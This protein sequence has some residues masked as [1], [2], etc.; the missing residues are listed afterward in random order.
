[1]LLLQL[2]LEILTQIFNLVSDHENVKGTHYNIIKLYIACRGVKYFD[3]HLD[4]LM[5]TIEISDKC[6]R[7]NDTMTN[8]DMYITA[9]RFIFSAFEGETTYTKYYYNMA[10]NPLIARRVRELELCN[11][12]SNNFAVLSNFQN[13]L[14]LQI[15]SYTSTLILAQLPNLENLDAKY[16]YCHSKV[17][18]PKMHTLKV[19]LSN[20]EYPSANSP[21]LSYD[22]V[23]PN[24][25]CL[26]IGGLNSYSIQPD[27]KIGNLGYLKKLSINSCGVTL[28]KLDQL[29]ELELHGR[30]VVIF[31]KQI[32]YSNFRRA[33][34][35][36]I[37][38]DC[39]PN[40][41]N[42]ITFN[43]Y[44]VLCSMSRQLHLNLIAQLERQ[45]ID[46]IMLR[47]SMIHGLDLKPFGKL[48]I[49]S[50]EFRTGVSVY[51]AGRTLDSVKNLSLDVGPMGQLHLNG[52]A[53]LINLT[54]SD[55]LTLHNINDSLPNFFVEL[56]V[57]IPIVNIH[58]SLNTEDIKK[59]ICAHR[60]LVKDNC[61]I[62]DCP[63]K[64][65]ENNVLD[66]AF[67]KIF[68]SDRTKKKIC[69]QLYIYSRTDTKCDPELLAYAAKAK[70]IYNQLRE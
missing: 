56:I 21:I 43:A 63:D 61:K 52:I 65:T 64:T 57:G 60:S 14:R 54:N 11:A 15:D 28:G 42:F 35:I 40:L 51:A 67:Q 2:A 59:F 5:R 69:K 44:D 10:K 20:F 48:N 70:I 39:V 25:I 18:L 16:I 26:S 22:I 29:E 24:L 32:V 34:F 45:R 58:G 12:R 47:F 49:V 13:L 17:T 53:Q 46:K 66:S 31:D 62:S 36:E 68:I 37:G 30:P 38:L 33:Q 27:V 8:F 6:K 9:R 19:V 1:M 55:T 41:D 3:A 4:V 50:V 23:F 7:R